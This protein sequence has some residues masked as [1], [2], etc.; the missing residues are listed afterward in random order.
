MQTDPV[1]Y[2]GGMNL[3]AYSLNDPMNLIDP[4]GE[5]PIGWIVRRVVGGL[6][7]IA[8]V[9]SRRQAIRARRRGEDVQITRGG[10]RE[11]TR[12]QE[13]AQG[14][15]RTLRHSG[16]TLRDGSGEVGQ[17]HVQDATGRVSGH[18]FYDVGAG[19]LGGL[20]TIL[21]AADPTHFESTTQCADLNACDPDG[22]VITVEDRLPIPVDDMNQEQ[23][24]D[25]TEQQGAIS[26]PSPQ[27]FWGG[28]LVTG[29][30][31]RGTR[32]GCPE[33]QAPC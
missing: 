4:N 25:G 3:Y 21:E 17:R 22:N 6:E 9:H 29:V 11:A 15:N 2:E 14:H 12:V 18:T 32:V 8:A 19:I 33:G 5:F 24:E 7:R 10:R 26:A 31:A 27:G 13:A 23:L 30:A 1:W 16:H 20:L 28:G